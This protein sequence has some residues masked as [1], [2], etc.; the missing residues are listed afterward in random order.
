MPKYKCVNKD[1]PH[2]LE[3]MNVHGTRITIINGKA[4]DKNGICFYCG[5]DREVVREEGMTTNIAGTNDQRNRM[6]KQW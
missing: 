6:A 3:I 5:D 4:V 2:Y 1:C